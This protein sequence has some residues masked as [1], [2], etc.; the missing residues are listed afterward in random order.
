MMDAFVFQEGRETFA[1][2]LA[3]GTDVLFILIDHS[4]VETLQNHQVIVCLHDNVWGGRES[5]IH[6]IIKKNNEVCLF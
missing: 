5:G 6:K 2:S 4:A 3:K 1:L